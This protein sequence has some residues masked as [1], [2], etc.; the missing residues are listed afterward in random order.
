MII[1]QISFSTSF[2]IHI[3]QAWFNILHFIETFARLNSASFI[4]WV[5]LPDLVLHHSFLVHFSDLFL[6]L[7]FQGTFCSLH[8][9]SCISSTFARLDSL[10]FT[11]WA[12]SVDSIHYPCMHAKYP[13]K[14]EA[15]FPNYET[16]CVMANIPW[17]N[18][19][20]HGKVLCIFLSCD[21]PDQSIVLPVQWR[22]LMANFLK[23]N[24]AISSY[25]DR[26]D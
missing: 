13:T 4:F 16:V 26:S 3:Y 17:W 21:Q 8:L 10:F 15:A 19:L 5:H 9:L 20:V 18:G 14:C 24:A 22:H 11:F 23:C 6:H 1:Y 7:S 2:S 25:S 12:H